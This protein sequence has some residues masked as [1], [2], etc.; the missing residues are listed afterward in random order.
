M[1]GADKAEAFLR[2]KVSVGNPELADFGWHGA[3]LTA[4]ELLLIR[5]RTQSDLLAHR[6]RQ[7]RELE[8]FLSAQQA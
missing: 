7:K 6:R 3:W 5:E 1:L 2:E 4:Q 8:A